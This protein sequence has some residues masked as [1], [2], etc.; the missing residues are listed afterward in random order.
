MTQDGT[1]VRNLVETRLLARAQDDRVF[2]DLLLENPRQAFEREFGVA[3]PPGVKMKVIEE[4]VDSFVLVLPA[5]PPAA[6]DLTD[7][8]LEQ[9]TGGFS[10]LQ[11][12]FSEALKTIGEGLSTVAR[13]G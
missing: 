11:S 2:H 6:G 3:L 5:Q 12:A 13:K 4:P 1:K 10:M 7:S 8:Q 9:V